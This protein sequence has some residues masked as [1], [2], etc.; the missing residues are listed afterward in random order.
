M[1]GPNV[2]DGKGAPPLKALACSRSRAVIPVIQK[3]LMPG[4]C[5]LGFGS[6]LHGWQQARIA[7]QPFPDWSIAAIRQGSHPLAKMKLK[8]TVPQKQARKYTTAF[9]VS[10]NWR[11][12]LDRVTKAALLLAAWSR[13]FE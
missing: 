10:L 9:I 7:K 13:R 6:T 11:Q 5:I 8:I 12:T 3:K 1:F 4:W 2:S